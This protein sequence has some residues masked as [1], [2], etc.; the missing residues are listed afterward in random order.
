MFRARL[1]QARVLKKL[2]NAF[3]DLGIRHEKIAFSKEG[4]MLR[5]MDKFHIC[6]VEFFLAKR[7]FESYALCHDLC[8]SLPIDVASLATV[9]KK[10]NN[11]DVCTL[12]AG[13]RAKVLTVTI[14]ARDQPWLVSKHDVPL[15]D[16]GSEY[17]VISRIQYDAKITMIARIVHELH[18]LSG[19]VDI[20]IIHEEARFTALDEGMGKPLSYLQVHYDFYE[21]VLKYYIAPKITDEEEN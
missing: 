12:K 21:G 16:P 11:D 18:E 15:I 19:S 20:Q 17:L 5:G 4:I 7:A 10:T 2:V 9:L 1:E 3:V 13:H 6:Q 14:E 8:M